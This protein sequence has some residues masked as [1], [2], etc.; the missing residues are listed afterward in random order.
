[1]KAMGRNVYRILMRA[2]SPNSGLTR[3]SFNGPINS[4]FGDAP[5]M[6]PATMSDGLPIEVDPWDYHGRILWL[7]GS[8]DIKVSRTVNA[9]LRPGDIFLDI[10]ANYGT[11]GFSARHV[12]G[13][14]GRVHLFEPQPYLAQKLTQ[15]TRHP[16]VRN[17]DVH[18]VALF[19]SDG[20]M[21]LSVPEHHSGKATLV[22]ELEATGT[23]EWGR[24]TVPVRRTHDYVAPLVGPRP[25]GVKIDIEG[26]EPHVLGD[27][28]AMTTLK[29]VV[30]EGDRNE[31]QLFAD[32]A[33]AGFVIFGLCRTVFLPRV[34]RVDDLARWHEF[35][36]F[37]AVRAV[38]V[39]GAAAEMSAKRLGQ[40]VNSGRR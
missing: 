17:V 25:F 35:H 22:P 19:D 38:A 8:N 27:L 11:I 21:T 29:F 33:A 13:A 2:L 1:M 36:D 14:A 26:A 12:V 31:A 18:S 6:M 9:L 3:L 7:F 10:G 40:L 28:L 5:A 16:T 24:V 32:F 37:V 34:R 15:L 39:S 4:L 20:E 23:S 30:F